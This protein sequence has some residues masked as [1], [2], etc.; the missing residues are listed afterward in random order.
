MSDHH[1]WLSDEQFARMQ[2]LLPNKPRGVPRV[3]DRRVISGIVHVIRNGL[4]W[5][6]APAVL[7]SAQDLVQPLRAL[8][9]GGGVRPDLRSPCRRQR[10]DRHRD[11]RRHPS[12]G[13]S[14][15]SEPA[16]K[17]AVPRRIGRTKGGLNSKLHA[18]CDGDGKPLILL[19]TEGQ[20]S[21]YRGAATLLPALPDAELLVADR[22]YESNWFR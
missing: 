4:M 14:H 3:D 12:Q 11:D 19:L 10:C 6:D 8:E 18:V 13:A 20:V 17:G 15:R 7:W 2:P 16:Q 21:D 5:R 9:P 1:F 22:D